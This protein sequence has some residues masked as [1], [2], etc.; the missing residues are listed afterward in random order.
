[1]CM[2]SYVYV[3]VS[4]N[5]CFIKAAWNGRSIPFP[6]VGNWDIRDSMSA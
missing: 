4:A 2:W 6:F 5:S 3:A 1:M